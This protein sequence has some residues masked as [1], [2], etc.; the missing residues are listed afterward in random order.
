MNKSLDE[1]LNFYKLVKS[2]LE[3]HYS[4]LSETDIFDSLKVYTLPSDYPT[5]RF[6]DFDLDSA[7]KG[8]INGVSCNFL[9]KIIYIDD[10]FYWRKDNFAHKGIILTNPYVLNCDSE[11]E[12]NEARNLRSKL[13]DIGFKGTEYPHIPHPS[14]LP[15]FIERLESALN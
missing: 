2:K 3:L 8:T 1:R 7:K 4:H 12:K 5:R 9:Q 13:K 11:R 15:V 14:Q 10:R 6:E